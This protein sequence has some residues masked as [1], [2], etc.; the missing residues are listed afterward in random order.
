MLG[1]ASVLEASLNRAQ[2][3]YDRCEPRPRPGIVVWGAPEALAQALRIV[4]VGE[5]AG[6]GGARARGKIQDQRRRSDAAAFVLEHA[7]D[8]MRGRQRLRRY[9]L[10]PPHA[11]GGIVRD[12]KRIVGKEVDETQR[13]EFFGGVDVIRGRPAR[14]VLPGGGRSVRGDH[15]ESGDRRREK[16]GGEQANHGWTIGAAVACDSRKL[17]ALGPES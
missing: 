13:V 11:L 1:K 15:V 3:R 8:G 2:L 4:E 10:P 16:P 14:A 17:D 9:A 12:V 7:P 5:R 6:H